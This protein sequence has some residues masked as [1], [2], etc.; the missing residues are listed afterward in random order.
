[1]CGIIAII[2]ADPNGSAVTDI[3]NGLQILQH[4]GQDACGIA[5]CGQRGRI[6]TRKGNGLCSEVFRFPEQLMDL[7]G[8]MGLG[9]CMVPLNLFPIWIPVFEM[10]YRSGSCCIAPT[11]SSDSLFSATLTVI[12]SHVNVFQ[13]DKFLYEAVSDCMVLG[14]RQCAILPPAPQQMPKPSHST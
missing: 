2:L 9:H 4:R 3:H 5:T 1:M 7:P 12:V 13:M 11:S 6:Y 14:C 10:M 8:N